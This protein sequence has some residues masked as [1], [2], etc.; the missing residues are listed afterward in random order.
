M[1]QTTRHAMAMGCWRASV[2]F[3]SAIAASGLT[4]M[5]TERFRAPE[6][7]ETQLFIRWW[8]AYAMF[9]V[10]LLFTVGWFLEKPTKPPDTST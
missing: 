7:T 2:L 8:W 10:G 6:L 4:I 1:K 3:C 9:G 5:L